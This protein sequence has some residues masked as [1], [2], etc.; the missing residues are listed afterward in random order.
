MD[1]VLLEAV[2]SALREDVS[3]ITRDVTVKLICRDGQWWVVPD[4]E[5]LNTVSGFGM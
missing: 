3:Y 4:Q 2:Q 5:L 1:R